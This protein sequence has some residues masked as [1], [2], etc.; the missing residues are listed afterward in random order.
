MSGGKVRVNQSRDTTEDAVLQL[1]AIHHTHTEATCLFLMSV[2]EGVTDAQITA[3]LRQGLPHL[4]NP[5]SLQDSRAGKQSEGTD[6][7]EKDKQSTVQK[8]ST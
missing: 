4:T 1:Q 2:T 5:V 7:T 6:T 3:A 8:K